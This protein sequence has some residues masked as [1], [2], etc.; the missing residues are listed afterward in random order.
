MFSSSSDLK[1][2]NS[3]YSWNCKLAN[4]IAFK[5]TST[6]KEYYKSVRQMAQFNFVH[7]KMQKK[8]KKMKKKT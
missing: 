5:I 2:L 1:Y 4:S 8:K 6:K 7:L 3:V